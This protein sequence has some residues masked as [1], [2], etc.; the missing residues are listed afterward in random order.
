MP[1]SSVFVTKPS[2]KTT[3]CAGF[4]L[5]V[6]TGN[7]GL[8]V[9]ENATSACICSRAWSRCKIFCSKQLTDACY[10][11][12]LYYPASKTD[13]SVFVNDDAMSAWMCSRCWS[14]CQISSANSQVLASSTNYIQLQ[15]EALALSSTKFCSWRLEMAGCLTSTRNFRFQIPWNRSTPDSPAANLQI[16]L[17]TSTKFISTFKDRRCLDLTLHIQNAK[18]LIQHQTR[19][20]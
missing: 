3:A 2:T 12:K 16:M 8:S 20:D 13:G 6:K 7:G 11:D 15:N 17:A 9:L 18:S 4:N 14:R 19:D 1:R 10:L 5:F